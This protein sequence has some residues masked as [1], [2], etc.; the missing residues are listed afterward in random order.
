MFQQ[1]HR[2]VSHFKSLL[3]LL[4]LSSFIFFFFLSSYCLMS[5]AQYCLLHRILTYI[6]YYTAVVVAV[7]NERSTE[8]RFE[9]R[10]ATLAKKSKG[11]PTLLACCVSLIRRHHHRRRGNIQQPRRPASL[12]Q[13]L[14]VSS[15][16]PIQF[17]SIQFSRVQAV[18]ENERR[19]T[20]SGKEGSGQVKPGAGGSISF[21]VDET[22]ATHT[23][24]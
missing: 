9:Q 20:S 13:R 3:R 6:E 7:A 14:T 2:I 17:S 12:G 22:Y 21:T 5:N 23:Q 1:A 4:P 18:I 24:Q 11:E 19:P 8:A 15:P 16:T 10:K